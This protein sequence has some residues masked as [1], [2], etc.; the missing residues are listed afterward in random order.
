MSICKRVLARC[1]KVLFNQDTKFVDLALQK[2]GLIN[3]LNHKIIDYI[4]RI[5]LNNGLPEGESEKASGWFQ[6]VSDIER[7][8]DHAENVVKL[9]EFIINNRME[10]SGAATKEL[11]EM[12]EVADQ[13]VEKA[14]VAL[15]EQNTE[16][17]R[18]VLELESKLDELEVVFRKNH[19]MR[20]N[21][22]LC[23]SGAGT[24]YLDLLTNLERI[25]DHVRI[26]L[27]SFCTNNIKRIYNGL[28]RPDL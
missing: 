10:F 22:N 19:I 21:Q 20:L 8:G 14:L 18:A 11:Q 15:E 9:A 26:L 28:S 4:T 2:E 3:E 1:D 25:G 7:I 5:H 24:I 17:A 23:A 16:M 12:M 13:T 6:A 27:N